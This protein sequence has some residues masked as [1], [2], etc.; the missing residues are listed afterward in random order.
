MQNSSDGASM[1][2]HRPTDRSRMVAADLDAA[3]CVPHCGRR[4][5]D[6]HELGKL[7]AGGISRGNLWPEGHRVSEFYAASIADKRTIRSGDGP[8][9]RQ[10]PPD[11]AFRVPRVE[12][13][14]AGHPRSGLRKLPRLPDKL[15][16]RME[17]C[18]ERLCEIAQRLVQ[19]PQC[20]LP[21]GRQTGSRPG[22]RLERAS[23]VGRW[24][25]ALFNL[26]GGRRGHRERLHATI[27]ITARPLVHMRRTHFDAAKVCAE[28]LE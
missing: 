16:S 21:R 5:D 2:S 11:G 9:P 1:A 8:G 26:V 20:L 14:R 15:Q 27:P 7:Q 3:E 19:L 10:E 4:M 17:H 18:Q 23:S 24:G 12:N 28:L 22:Y 13:H 25:A 6:R